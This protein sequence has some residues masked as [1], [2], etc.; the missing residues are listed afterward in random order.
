MHD[1]L[2]AQLA[3]CEFA[4]TKSQLSSQMIASE[5]ENYEKLSHVIEKGVD[6]AKDHIESSKLELKHAKTIRKNRMEYDLLAKVINEQ[7]DRKQTE[8]K[9]AKLKKELSSLEQSKEQVEKKIDLRRKQ[10]HVLI[11]SIQQLQALLEE[12]DSDDVLN[13]SVE[14]EDM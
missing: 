4:V 2:Q 1:K 7:P 14:D 6:N 11:S 5:L 13:I 9:L 3:Q 8:E 12:K 10:F